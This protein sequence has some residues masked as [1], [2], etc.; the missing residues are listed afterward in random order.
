MRASR[1]KVKKKTNEE[2]MKG[3]RLGSGTF[4][5]VK[6]KL[7]GARVLHQS[8]DRSQESKRKDRVWSECQLGSFYHNKEMG[9]RCSQ[10][11]GTQKGLIFCFKLFSSFRKRRNNNLDLK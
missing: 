1:G 8:M 10:N 9:L 11:H 4:R 2:Q 5:E 7:A 6:F 3:R